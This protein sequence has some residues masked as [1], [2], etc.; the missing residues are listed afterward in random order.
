MIMESCE[1]VNINN[2]FFIKNKN[3]LYIFV[4]VNSRVL[5]K[6][7]AYMLDFKI[8]IAYFYEIIA[9]FFTCVII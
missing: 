4:K 9:Y 5:F 3:L 8:F 7:S 6:M 2:F 1:F